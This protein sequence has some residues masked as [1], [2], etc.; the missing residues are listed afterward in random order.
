MKKFLIL[1]TTGILL[2]AAGGYTVLCT[3]SDTEHILPGV[4]VRGVDV[5]NMTAEDAVRAL[6]EEADRNSDHALITVSLD[7]VNYTAR[8]EG[9]AELDYET[10]VQEALQKTPD[11]FWLRG[12][13]WLKAFQ[14]GN[15]VS[16]PP[17]KTD[18]DALCAALISNGFPD[19]DT[20]IRQPV[21]VQ[22]DRLVFSAGAVEEKIDKETLVDRMTETYEKETYSEVIP[23]PLT[24]AK[25]A[26][27]EQIYQE[28]HKEPENAT[29]D[30]DHNYAIVE[31]KPGIDFDMEQA[32]KALE[33]AKSGKEASIDLLYPQPEV[34]ARDLEERMFSDVLATYT[35]VVNDTPNAVSNIQLATKKCSEIILPSGYEFS[36]NKAVGEQT[37]A[38]GFKTADA[39]LDGKIIQAYGGGICQVSTTIF[40]ASLYANLD[41]L[42]HW[43]HDYVS[44]Y[45]EAGMDAAVA[46]GVLDMRVGNSFAYPVKIEVRCTGNNLT[47]TIFGT[48]TDDSFVEI[49]TEVLQ[50]SPPHTMEVVTH[51]NV[52]TENKRHVF[53]EKAAYSSYVQ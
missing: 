18:P 1:L 45:I 22:G 23:C 2:L 47:A 43:N 52:Y 34:H 28:I 25:A 41:I 21:T 49:E 16:Q 32:R 30:P 10:A 6:R 51:R 35:T 36:F 4:T 42:E 3:V 29:L 17:V 24:P 12:A 37:A 50:N 40:A 15:P 39:I 31:G 46:W 8:A 14:G 48:K 44:S 53:T 7:G 5:G 26:D 38:T 13:A 11:E 27:L 9:A 33:T 20:Y 19:I